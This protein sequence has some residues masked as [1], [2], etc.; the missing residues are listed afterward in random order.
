MT[1]RVQVKALVSEMKVMIHI[2][3]HLNLINILGAI[4]KDIDVGNDQSK[5]KQ[6]S[7]SL[8]YITHRHFK[9]NNAMTIIQF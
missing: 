1:D 8:C 2:G 9:N 5:Y 4:T 7:T 3:R 6:L